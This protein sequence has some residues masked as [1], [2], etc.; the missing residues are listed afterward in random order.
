MIKEAFELIMKA[1]EEAAAA[2]REVRKVA[3]DRMEHADDETLDAVRQVM[4]KAE[5]EV[6]KLEDAARNLGEKKAAPILEL[7]NKKAQHFAQLSDKEIQ[8]AVDF[9]VEKVTGYGNR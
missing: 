7:A 6:A 2:V 5:K 4:T 9:V 1:E 3:K 8:K